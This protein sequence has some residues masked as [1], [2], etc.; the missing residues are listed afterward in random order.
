MAVHTKCFPF[1]EEIGEP[2]H[3]TVSNLLIYL[4]IFIS[5]ILTIRRTLSRA[6]L[7]FHEFWYSWQNFL[8]PQ[9]GQIYLK[10][11]AYHAKL[12]SILHSRPNT[13]RSCTKASIF[14]ASENSLVPGLYFT[15]E[16]IA[17]C[18]WIQFWVLGYS[19]GL[20]GGVY[21]IIPVWGPTP[22]Q[23]SHLI[24]EISRNFAIWSMQTYLLSS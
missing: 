21:G 24:P 1:V 4:L 16:Y 9:I 5:P 18:I 7:N 23:T 8:P 19:G 13:Q 10:T 12:R 22:P 11:G 17:E 15:K 6:E 2:L 20:E 3:V 14:K